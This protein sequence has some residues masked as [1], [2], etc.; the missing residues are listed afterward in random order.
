MKENLQ[1]NANEIGLMITPSSGKSTITKFQETKIPIPR[2]K[3]Q[4]T[5]VKITF[6]TIFDV[7]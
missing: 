1:A 2:A 4:A 7:F 3:I 5:A 6:S